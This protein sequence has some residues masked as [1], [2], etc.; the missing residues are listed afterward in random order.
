MSKVIEL[1][2]FL[3]LN[4]LK[5][6][7]RKYCLKRFFFYYGIICRRYKFKTLHNVTLRAI[8]QFMGTSAKIPV[9]KPNTRKSTIIVVGHARENEKI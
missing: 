1:S 6:R 4:L 8:P 5:K 9:Y 3:T 2:V 7:Y